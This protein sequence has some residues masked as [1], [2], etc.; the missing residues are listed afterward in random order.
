M[1][2]FAVVL[3]LGLAACSS[4][5]AGAA[6]SAGS[7]GA[8]CAEEPAT[9]PPGAVCLLEAR[10]RV[11]D[12]SGA[13]VPEV[14]TSVCGPIC[15]FGETGSDGRF[16]VPIGTQLLPAEYST[17]VHG[18]PSLTSFFWPLPP[19][20]SASTLDVGDLLVLPLPASG[21][22]LVVKQDGQGA[23]A[24]SV[25]SGDVT[26]EVADGVSVRIDVEDAV[27]GAEGKMFRALAIPSEH[28]SAF[29]DAS[30]G[31]FALYALSPFEAALIDAATGE[32]A[33]ARLSFANTTSLSPGTAVEVVALGSY[34]YP[35]WVAPAAFEPVATA[36][37]SANGAEIELDAGAGVQYLTWVGLR[38]KP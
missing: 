30:L 23:P 28:R 22:E 11:V 33:G 24:Q 16:V 37:V 14:S 27:L 10:G 5:G 31:L 38:E 25:T 32:A 6:G 19:D 17:L 35:D 15:F 1:R 7:A 20:L 34:Q 21:A 4:D 8:P 29:V 12:A 13:P 18:R 26:L 2:A 3:G 36:S 9:L